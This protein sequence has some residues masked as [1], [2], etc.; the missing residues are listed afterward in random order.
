MIRYLPE[1]DGV[2]EL[3]FGRGDDGYKALRAGMC[4]VG[5]AGAGGTGLI[6]RPCLVHWVAFDY[7]CMV[8]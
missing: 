4:W 6:R 7:R 2:T 8:M 1:R 3:D 5:A